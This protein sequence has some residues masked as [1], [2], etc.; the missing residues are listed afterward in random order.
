MRSTDKP[1][2]KPTRHS[3]PTSHGTATADGGHPTVPTSQ[4]A[5]GIPTTTP[6][7]PVSTPGVPTTTPS[8]D[9]RGQ[10]S[11][12]GADKDTS[13]SAVTDNGTSAGVRHL[14]KMFE[15]C[16]SSETGGATTG[17]SGTPP[18]GAVTKPPWSA[19]V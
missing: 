9:S 19:I 15:R 14:S 13:T 2:T 10:E 4:T 7:I 11:Q 5:S 3:A 8:P 1:T 16:G 12:I 18:A 6:G 17:P